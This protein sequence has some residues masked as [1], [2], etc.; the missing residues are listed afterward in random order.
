MT[1]EGVSYQRGHTRGLETGNPSIHSARY[2]T[3]RLI[4]WGWGR[5]YLVESLTLL[6][7]PLFNAKH[8][9]SWPNSH[10]RSSS[11]STKLS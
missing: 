8:N 11:L 9:I 7:R 4:M 3:C 2:S 6:W 1:S 5:G 10:S